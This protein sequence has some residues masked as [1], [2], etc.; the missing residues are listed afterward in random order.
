M[1]NT[2]SLLELEAMLDEA[3]DNLNN[4]RERVA[5]SL[6]EKVYE[7]LN[8]DSHAICC[9]AW[10]HLENGNPT[11]AMEYSDL[12]VKIDEEATEP[13]L[14]RGF[15]L[16]R[17]GIFDGA[18]QDLNYVIGKADQSLAQAH[19]LKASCL[20]GASRYDEALAEFENAIISDNG[21]SKH[22][23]K[24]REW[25]RKTAGIKTSFLKKLK[26]KDKPLI[27]EAE[28][29]FKAR[30][31]WFSL[32]AVRKIL[33]DASLSDLHQRAILLELETMFAMFQYK[34]ALN[35]AEELKNTFGGVD[36]FEVIY[37]K[38][39]Q[40][41][42]PKKSSTD[43]R[44]TQEKSQ[45]ENKII[46]LKRRTDFQIIE[47][48][49]AKTIYAKTFDLIEQMSTGNKTYILQFVE[50]E[51]QYIG[52]EVVIQNPFA[53]QGN[54]T[55][56]GSAVWSLNN[57]E[58]GRHNFA[59]NVESDWGT[60]IFSQSWGTDEP[61]F[62]KRGQ[63]KVDIYINGEKTVEKW[64]LVGNS[65]IVDYESPEIYFADLETNAQQ[66]MKT[67]A[68]QAS[69][70]NKDAV[71]DMSVDEILAELDKFTGLKA[72]KQ[73]MRDFV[74]YLEFIKERKKLGLKTQEGISLH[75]VFLGNPGTGKT[76]IARLLGKVFKAMGLLPSGHLVEVDRSSLVGQYIGETAQKTEKII[77][78]SIGGLLFIDEAYTLVKKGGS[79]QDFG[80]EAIDTLLKR[81][82]DRGSE[83]AVIAAGYPD[84]MNSFLESN[85]GMKSRFTHF[86][87]F[88]D[89][90][91]DEMIE[92]FK[93]MAKKED[94]NIADAAVEFLKKELILLYRKR[95][96]TFGNARLV[97]NLFNDAKMKLGKRYLKLP[98]KMRD[99]NALSTLSV[100]DIEELF[101]GQSGKTYKLVIDEEN[102]KIALD[103]LNTFTG[104]ASVKKE[105]R[106]LVKLAHYYIEQG[107][108]IQ[109][110]FS[111]HI[112]FTG[113]PGTGKTTLAR[114]FS[115][116]YSALGILPKGHLVEA[117]RQSLVAS[118]VGKT[119]EKTT[120]IIN[121]ALGGTLFIDEAYA[122]VKAG[123]NSGSDF[124]KEAI[125]TL[126]KR[127]EDDRGKFI[128][129]AAGY[130]DDMKTF[131]DSNVGLQ[132]RFT[133]FI[134]F[135]DF[136]PDELMLMT[137]NSLKEKE[138]VLEEN[139]KELLKKHFNEIYRTRDKTFGNA[140]LIRN[141]VGAMIK[142]QVLRI[143]EISQEDL[144][145][146][147]TKT[148]TVD[149]IKPIVSAAPVK[150]QAR[151]EGNKELLDQYLLELKE[152]TGLESVKRSVEKLI[153]GLK[154]SKLR[155]E[156]GLK[157]I[158]K[159][160]H[161]VFLGNPG[162]G[163]TTIARLISQI[164]KE[165]GLLQKGHLVEVDRSALVAGYSGQTSKK[166]D[167]V[168]EQ[169]LGGTLF[170]DEAYTLSRGSGDFGQEAIDTL[171]KRM[172]DYRDQLVVIVAG[173]PNEMK[174]FIDSNPGLQSRFTNYFNFEDYNP[175]EML[176]IATMISEKNGYNLDEGALQMLLGK[177]TELY[178]N[179]DM[180]FGNARTV[181]NILYKAINNQEERILV[182][183]NPTN[184]VL[185][186]ITYEDIENIDMREF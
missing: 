134:N 185:T 165:L 123:D 160:L 155:E 146:D 20:A 122:L 57:E 60:V 179:R 31:F 13:R 34:P 130:T 132:S 44:T 94:Y 161:A 65:V 107:E 47:K 181:R 37:H 97:R 93:Q 29:A 70:G 128:V 59:L 74:D 52:V 110:R 112:V 48:A 183:H 127:M 156:R 18:L 42:R 174:D 92:I 41:N 139:A 168:I 19:H 86:F 173:Y 151:V 76:T 124:G 24:L 158:S 26:G 153:T 40:T 113:N 39:S 69:E 51:I 81:M 45:S 143:V 140:R 136:N 137:I 154:V 33:T 116:I 172:E 6:A 133:K 111:D 43:I 89:F 99:K 7:N 61:G 150:K 98:E 142:N 25:F 71:P 106:E 17:M 1:D 38:L 9:L 68:V 117:D 75:T 55:I 118:Y 125:D 4:G 32:W 114:L 104:L 126:L 83:F 77:T 46:T 184:E 180:N 49:S 54:I 56:N 8:E 36:R 186:S 73:A 62:W 95:D 167:Q 141:L 145:E 53:K 91:P 129:I 27:D 88:E 14:Y 159:N 87:D 169:A 5:L 163:K 22:Y 148:I 90:T 100:A 15:I 115:Q 67:V 149:D 121:R 166:T 171:L 108:D 138:L 162:T 147:I 30:E 119:A 28:E 21:Q 178:Q 177:F 175:R 58:V 170:I 144:S 135:E 63:G 72:V 84:E 120:E 16:M 96:K 64:F 12:A 2:R 105:I 164:Y 182:V 50:S 109:S 23:L 79:G 80:Q 176:E 10:A 78:D 157:V 35:K 152:L 82:E 103:K 102:L 11:Q 131:L 85:P 66:D 3:F 101:K